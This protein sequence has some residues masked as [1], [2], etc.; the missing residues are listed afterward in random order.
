MKTGTNKELSPY[1]PDWLYVRAG[2][3]PPTSYP[4]SLLTSSAAIARKLYLRQNIGIGTLKHLYGGKK[5]RGV[6]PPRHSTGSKKIIR[7]C[8]QQLEEQKILKKVKKHD[9]KPNS[10]VVTNDGRRAM[11]NIANALNKEKKAE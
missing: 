11:D 1:N 9:L 8:M 10:R 7:Y 2:T 3:P 4:A 6:R 5:R